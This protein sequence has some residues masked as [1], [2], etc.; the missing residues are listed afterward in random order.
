MYESIKRFPKQF[1]WEPEIKNPAPFL[2]DRV[3]FVIAGMGGS[4]LGGE[5]LKA[6]FANLDIKI[7]RDYGLP[8]ASPLSLVI[9]SSFSGNTEETV[10]AFL[11]ARRRG[12]PVAAVS[13][14]GKLLALAEKEKIP[15]VALPNENIQPRAA[16]GYSI[17]AIL[18]LMGN[19][20]ALKDSAE[21]SKSLNAEL[22]EEEGK[23]LAEGIKGK[24]PI[25]YSSAR[26]FPIAYNWKIKFNETGKIS[27][28]A[29]RLPELNHNEMTG[30]SLS[31][32]NLDIEV[33]PLN[34]KIFSFLFLEDPS[35]APRIIKRMQITKQ[36][37]ESR[38]FPISNIQFPTSNIWHKI[39]QNLLVADFTAYYLAE[40]YGHDPN[41]VP[42]VEEF[43]KLI[44]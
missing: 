36:L 15:Y 35:D 2:R 6:V 44:K 24:I 25:I 21:L 38:G 13:S 12:L 26:N 32:S 39:F 18:K 10:D 14:G 42:M 5:L 3:N 34:I 40:H 30:F 22:A 33:Q 27:A 20:D 23:K 9:A 11:E 16:L 8:A 7:H 29:N 17:R 4:A 43:K 1:L 19:E 41:F 31:R 28:F 37:L